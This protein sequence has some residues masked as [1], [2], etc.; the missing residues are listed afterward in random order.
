MPYITEDKRNEIEFDD[1]YFS[2]PSS[3]DNLIKNI[4]CAGDLNYTITRLTHEYLKKFG[5]KYQVYND[6]V[7]VL[8]CA[9]L[10]LYRRLAAPYE[11]YKAEQNGDVKPILQ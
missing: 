11:D 2:L 1:R 6:I 4:D 5:E 3:I 8:E 7:G 9:K 10:E